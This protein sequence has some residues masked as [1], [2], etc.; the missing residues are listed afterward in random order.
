MR[1]RS[2]AYGIHVAALALAGLVLATDVRAAAPPPCL[3]G[4]Y[5]IDSPPVLP[6]GNARISM[7]DGLIHVEGC[8]PVAATVRAKKKGVRVRAV[9]NAEQCPGI[10]KVR[11]KGRLDTA[12]TSMKG[13]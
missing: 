7:R 10:G 9:W 1:E 13:A 8:T 6:E 4:S 12:C 3:T 11:L 2:S 5:E